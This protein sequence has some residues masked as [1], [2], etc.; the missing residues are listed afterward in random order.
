LKII[1]IAIM[2]D[3]ISRALPSDLSGKILPAASDKFKT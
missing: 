3:D 2:K 1:I